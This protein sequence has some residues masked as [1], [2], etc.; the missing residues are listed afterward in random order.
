MITYYIVG[1]G[2]NFTPGD[3]L[4][5]TRN[6]SLIVY[7]NY[8]LSFHNHPIK[9]SRVVLDRIRREGRGKLPSGDWVLY[10]LLDALVDLYVEEVDYFNE[11]VDEL[12]HLVLA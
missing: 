6:V 4:L 3:D 5:K 11:E 8:I 9:S 1:Q 12:D 10:A 7:P 2:L